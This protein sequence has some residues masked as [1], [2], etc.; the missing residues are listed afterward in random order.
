MRVAALPVS[1]C[2]RST[3]PSCHHLSL[4][5]R[6]AW[7]LALAPQIPRDC[8]SHRRSEIRTLFS[9]SSI[10]RLNKWPKPANTRAVAASAVAV[11]PRP[12]GLVSAAPGRALLGL[13][14]PRLRH[15]CLA[16]LWPCTGQD[17]LFLCPWWQHPGEQRRNPRHGTQ[18]ASLPFSAWKIEV[19]LSKPSSRST[20]PPTRK[21]GPKKHL[22]AACVSLQHLPLPLAGPQPV[23]S[24][25]QA[26]RAGAGGCCCRE[27]G[28]HQ[29]VRKCLQ[30]LSLSSLL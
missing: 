21:E 28:D 3:C 17:V 15:G 18:S 30:L 8:F 29:K 5:G 24:L 2:L 13:R 23:S 16:K 7:G 25:R 11:F 19:S 6:N 10:L 20:V 9:A 14:A 1:R 22:S 26:Q 4:A 27:L 12:W